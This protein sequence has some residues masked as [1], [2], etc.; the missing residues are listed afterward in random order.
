MEIIQSG[1]SCPPSTFEVAYY[2]S[3][4]IECVCVC[5][6]LHPFALAGAMGSL[7]HSKC[8]IFNNKASFHGHLA[9]HVH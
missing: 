3:H 5:G 2:S 9:I 4:S 1:D 7:D 6:S 8:A